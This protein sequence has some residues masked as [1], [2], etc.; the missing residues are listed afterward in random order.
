MNIQIN[1]IKTERLHVRRLELSDAQ[2]ILEMFSNPDVT[3]YLNIQQMTS[4][5]QAEQFIKETHNG[6]QDYQLLELGI[7]ETRSQR[8][9]GTCTYSD[10]DQMNK[11]AEIVFALCKVSWGNGFMKELLPVFIL[12][13]FRDLGLH[14]IEADVDPRNLA[15]IRLLEHF[16]F[17]REGY[18][19]ERYHINEEIQDA[20]FY[21]LLKKEYFNTYNS[22]SL[23]TK[24]KCRAVIRLLKH[25]HGF[26]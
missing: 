26:L 18:L 1:T 24:L 22:N 20:V 4:L 15:S 2:A 12:F 3:K 5:S 9:I 25:E 14:R 17:K 16:G 7:I 10:W 23:S 21:G 19:R 8:L 13:G 6:F 11:R